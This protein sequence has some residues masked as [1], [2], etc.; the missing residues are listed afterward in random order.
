M[1][2][3]IILCCFISLFHCVSTAQTE[4]TAFKSSRP[5]NPK[6]SLS[7]GKKSLVGIDYDIV[8]HRMRL[9]IDPRFRPMTGEIT[10]YFKPIING[11]NTISFDLSDS[12]YVD[13]VK[14]R[15]NLL[16]YVHSSNA[17][18][19][20]L[21]GTLTLNQLDSITVWYGGD[22]TNN[23]SRSYERESGR[24]N[25]SAPLIW[26][27]S[28]PYGAMEWWPCK[29][30]LYDKIDSIDMH[31]VV[32]K[33]NKAA[34]MGNLVSTIEKGDSTL[35]FH[36]KHRYPIVTYLIGTAV[37]NYESFTDW[38]EFSNGD[39]LP[40]LNFVFPENRPFMES[41]VKETIPIMKLFDSLVGVYPFMNEKYGHAEFLRGGGM[42]HQTMSFMGSWNFGLIAHELAHQWFGNQVTCG[43]WSDLWLNEGFATYFTLLARESLQD[44][45]TWRLVQLG[46][47]ERALREDY[48]SVYVLDTFDQSRL[49]S[50]HL[51][52]NKGAQLLRMIHW[53]LGDSLFYKS[54]RN[55][56]NDKENSYAFAR[57]SDLKFHL[58]S[59]SRNDLTEFFDDWYYG[60]GNPHYLINWSQTG[61]LVNV[62]V[63]QTTNGSTDFFEMPIQ[64][65][66]RN[67]T[68]SKTVIINPSSS[69]FE[70]KI[71]IDFA[72]DSVDFDPDLWVLATHDVLNTSDV[73]KTV[74]LYPN[75]AENSITISSHG[76]GFSEFK[77][78]DLIGKQVLKG[79]FKPDDQIFETID[80]S[81]LVNG[82]F[83]I[84][85][86]SNDA[87]TSLKFI[88]L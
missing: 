59:T 69:E 54:L 60:T 46:S 80:L 42:E 12:L 41:A 82:L 31:V 87:K 4:E 84:D 10:S 16:N 50:S 45:A 25:S 70:T 48:Q 44:Q 35:E 77:I 81:L 72:V 8:Y 51:T 40:I 68:K 57:T 67:E 65:R 38:V 78:F 58:E 49:F 52:Y 15:G 39:S 9:N 18:E 24:A 75:P 47:Q 26:T 37:T 74:L 14:H 36:W 76:Y 1:V 28:Q 13:S 3:N 21:G 83:I 19:I 29:Q 66:L 55:Y 61:S 85:L 64:L 53:Q 63:K 79:S 86:M 43:S 22:P 7:H 62:R 32:P 34:G 56:L 33:G 6:I 20:T 71:E 5:F 17:L 73:D 27:L 2:R 11:F 23:P 88:K 30:S